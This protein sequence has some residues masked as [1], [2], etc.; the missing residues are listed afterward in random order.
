MVNS[1]ED[2]ACGYLLPMKL[3]NKQYLK[4]NRT[5]LS[6]VQ[7]NEYIEKKLIEFVQWLA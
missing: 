6:M 1:M 7:L 5:K 4:L 3:R 2:C